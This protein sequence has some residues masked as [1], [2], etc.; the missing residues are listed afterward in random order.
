MTPSA[1]ER[2]GSHR[3][4]RSGRTASPRA[5]VVS[6]SRISPMQDAI[7]SSSLTPDSFTNRTF[8]GCLLQ[9]PGG[10]RSRVEQACRGECAA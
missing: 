2:S 5:K 9:R 7:G 6:A 1:P 4:L 10:C 8:L 3:M